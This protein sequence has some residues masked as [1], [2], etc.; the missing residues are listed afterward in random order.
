MKTNQIN[1]NTNANVYK[2]MMYIK[3][4]F[5]YTRVYIYI[6]KDIYIY[7]EKYNALETKLDRRIFYDTILTIT[8]TNKQQ[9]I[10]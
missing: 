4:K 7:I 6:I 10:Q 3:Q 5:I 9:I 8:A 2:F 1:S